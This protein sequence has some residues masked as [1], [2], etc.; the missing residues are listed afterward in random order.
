MKKNLQT[1]AVWMLT[2]ACCVAFAA[3]GHEHTFSTDWL[4]DSENH[5]HACTEKD[6][7]EVSDKTAHVYDNACDAD[8]NVCG[9]TRT[10][11]EHVYDNACD[12]DCNI[13]G[14]TRTTKHV[15]DND[16]DTDC[17]VCGATRTVGEHVY[18]G[19]A[20]ATCNIC[21]E[22]RALPTRYKAN[23]EAEWNAAVNFKEMPHFTLVI[24]M[25]GS[26]GKIVRDGDVFYLVE[27]KSDE[28]GKQEQA[29]MYLVKSGD[30][31]Y[32]LVSGSNNPKHFD[33]KDCKEDYYNEIFE[34]LSYY[35]VR[36][37]K[38]TD[39]TYDEQTHKYANEN[40][41]CEHTLSF[42]GGVISKIES[43]VKAKDTTDSVVYKSTITFEQTS[44]T[45]PAVHTFATEWSHDNKDH[46]H[47]CTIEGCTEIST[48]EAHNITSDK[49]T[50]N[51]GFTYAIDAERYANALNFKDEN[52]KSYQNVD[53]I[54]LTHSGVMTGQYKVTKDAAY[55]YSTA[56]DLEN[57][58]TIWTNE[59]GKGV[60]YTKKTKDSEWIRTVQTEKFDDFASF[61]LPSSETKNI[62]TKIA[63]EDLTYNEEDQTYSGSYKLGSYTINAILRFEDGRLVKCI[64]SATKN[65]G[66]AATL[67]GNRT[68][69]YGN[70]AIEIPTADKV[71][72]T[73]FALPYDEADNEYLLENISF[74]AGKTKWF[75]F[76]VTKTIYDEN[77]G[78]SGS[79]D[80]TGSFDGSAV[81]TIEAENASGG[82]IEN[83]ATTNGAIYLEELSA[84]GTYY[85]KITASEACNGKLK[86]SFA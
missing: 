7:T 44:L 68:M 71:G 86:I 31:F 83:I 12:T 78:T 82:K 67:G 48:K 10:V 43:V 81:L 54:A 45:L 55:R 14:A 73:A 64:R 32:L 53:Y 29:E 8:C 24:D 23:N 17:N 28:S 50:C 30:S 5:W 66:S 84:A 33:R 61:V 25:G 57:L 35:A 2:L 38:Y 62:L 85:V 79:Y 6:C 47:V 72:K 52:G 74:S 37:A 27:S 60:V 70:A 19:E 41:T 36:E 59:D 75:A 46:W 65:D 1:L 76:E 11:G 49:K 56:S 77:K 21:G 20:D 15:Y 16:C 18:D 22:E 80:I 63:F 34:R 9:A 39:F 51:C 13:C 26:S 42:V 58:E 3:C 40:G 4:Q 69:T